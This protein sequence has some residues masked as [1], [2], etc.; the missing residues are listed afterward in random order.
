[1]N[2]LQVGLVIPVFNVE[3]TIGKVLASIAGSLPDDLAEILIIDN[4][5]TDATLSIIR[6]KLAAHPDLA[7][8]ATIIQHEENYGYGCSIKGG[9]DYFSKRDVSHVMVIH[10][11]HQVDPTWLIE[12]LL[13]A[14]RLDDG[15][16]LVLASRFKPESG[17][18]NYSLLRKLGNYFFNA[19]TTFCSGHHMSDS[20][21]AMIVMRKALLQ[22][23]PFRKLSNSWQFHPQLN[24]LLYGVP[25]VRI[26]EIPMDWADSDADSTVPLI[27]YGLILLKMLLL[28][29][30]KKNI[31]RMSPVEIFP[32][33]SI[34]AHRRFTVVAQSVGRDFALTQEKV[35]RAL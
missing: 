25:G 3:R 17:I 33:E 32:V 1:M 26:K 6:D 29:W 13:T 8:L 16:D 18:Q 14:I 35:R 7:A 9:F 23:V 10:G 12:K 28:Y 2:K 20:G 21:T 4:H 24:I 34:P 30:F 19:T 5:S 31:N 11:D 27:R 15:T 22:K